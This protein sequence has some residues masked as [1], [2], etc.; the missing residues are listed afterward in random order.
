MAGQAGGNRR[1]SFW[2]GGQGEVRLIPLSSVV[3]A[4]AAAVL[5]AAGAGAEAG[6]VMLMFF[7]TLTSLSFMAILLGFV[8]VVRR[9]RK[10]KEV[11]GGR[12][13]G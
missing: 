9:D 2:R 3:A 1:G 6:V 13:D 5:A 4:A 11:E 10:G 7:S 12:L 8:I